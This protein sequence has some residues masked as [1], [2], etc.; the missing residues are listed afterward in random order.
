M[1]TRQDVATEFIEHFRLQYDGYGENL[2]DPVVRWHLYA[3]TNEGGRLGESVVLRV[4][5]DL[6]I[7]TVGGSTIPCGLQHI[8]P[9]VYLQRLVRRGY[10]T[11]TGT[12]TWQITPGG[13]WVAEAETDGAAEGCLIPGCGS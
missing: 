5:A 2:D 13:A 9:H 1:T 11:R 7:W 10:A 8:R 12:D 6:R 3:W 4:L